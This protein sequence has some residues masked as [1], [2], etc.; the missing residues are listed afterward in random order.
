VTRRR[1]ALWRA[2]VAA[3]AGQV[4][5]QAVIEGVMMRSVGHWSVAVRTPE[6]DVALTD[7]PITPWAGTW[8]WL[9]LPL[10]RGVIA[11]GESLVIGMKALAI[12]A[13]QAAGEDEDGEEVLSKT[14][15]GVTL[16]FSLVLAVGLFFVLPVFLT[17]LLDLDSGFAFWAVEGVIRVAI[18]LAYIVGIS[19]IPDLRRVFQYHGA[20]HMTI[21]AH[22]R[23]EP[24]TAESASRFSLL[25]VRC[26]TAF[27]LIVM[28]ISIFVFA[29]VGTPGLGW[30]ILSRIV[31]VPI[32]AGLSYE[33]IRWAGR[34]QDQRYVQ[35][36]MT[37]GLW[38]QRLTTRRPD[39]DQLDVACQALRRVLELERTPPAWADKVEVM[40]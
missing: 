24:L 7:Q 10:I 3:P 17:S 32:V 14:H 15:I 4:G 11:L 18:F 13:S 35:I 21:H 16:A 38:L 19:F 20:E 25:H 8:R 22:E 1:R 5:G 36:I 26:G 27:L 30:L 28:V 33:V 29:A 9:R 31:G 6:G 34:H 2:V 37:P 39:L 23:G 12:S 40:A